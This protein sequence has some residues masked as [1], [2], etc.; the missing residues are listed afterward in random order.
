V[1]YQPSQFS[2][3]RGSA[4]P[5]IDHNSRGWKNAAAIAQ[6]ANDG[7]WRSPVEGALFFHAARVSPRWRMA[8]LAQ[9]GNHVFYR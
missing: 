6:I 4:M 7:S 8:R 5:S 3:V 2:F 9:I 1:V